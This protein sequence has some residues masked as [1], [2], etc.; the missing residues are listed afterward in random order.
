[1]TRSVDISRRNANHTNQQDRAANSLISQSHIFTKPGTSLAGTT[2]QN[3][4]FTKVFPKQT[5]GDIQILSKFDS[6][7]VIQNNS[8]NIDDLRSKISQMQQRNIQT[9]RIEPNSVRYV[10]PDESDVTL[11]V[12]EFESR[13][14]LPVHK[15][16]GKYP[17][18][19]F[20]RYM[21]SLNTKLF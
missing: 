9:A 15:K 13:F 21:A 2:Q 14:S 4:D 19:E 18:T 7:R 1:M 10:A 12:T 16:I 17:A 6:T 5:S 8:V 20:V 11:Q 3:T